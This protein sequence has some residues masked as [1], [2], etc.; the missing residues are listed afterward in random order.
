MSKKRKKIV[1]ASALPEDLDL[2]SATE[3]IA[4]I[5]E[6]IASAH[7]KIKFEDLLLWWMV[8]KPAEA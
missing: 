2:E 8:C 7:P 1:F 3:L 4:I 5:D 6:I